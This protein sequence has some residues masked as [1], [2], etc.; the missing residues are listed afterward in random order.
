M[1]K[2]PYPK[3][4]QA[5]TIHNAIKKASLVTREEA[6][7]DKTTPESLQ[8]A[9]FVITYNPMLPNIPKVL[10]DS[11]SI[12]HASER[13]TK[14]FK[15]L[16]LV[17]YRRARNLSDMFCSKRIAPPESSN[18]N[19]APGHQTNSGNPPANT[20]KCPEFGLILK[21]QKGLKIHQC[22][23]HQRKPNV[24]T[25]PGFWP[26]LSDARCDTCRQ[27]LFSTSVTSTKNGEIHNIK[28]PVTCKTKNVC[29]LINCK[30][31]ASSTQ[32]KQ[33]R[34]FI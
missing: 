25:S 28:Q 2:T 20:N 29:Y 21:N 4:R 5:K 17:S 11:Q 30:N 16:P 6:L 26:C 19:P 10:H 7:A 23:K 22:S 15:N 24:P 18:S 27:G 3:R 8:R 12:L 1:K 34:S 13:C 14:V 32:E 9:P 31:V 33:N